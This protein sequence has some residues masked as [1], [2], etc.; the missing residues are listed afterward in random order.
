MPST[1]SEPDNTIIE[2]AGEM[3]SLVVELILARD[4]IVNSGTSLVWKVD[5]TSPQA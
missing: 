1:L 4:Q 2:I 5:F 3:L